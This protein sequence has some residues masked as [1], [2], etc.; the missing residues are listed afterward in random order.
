MAR[1]P[2]VEVTAIGYTAPIFTTIGA[3]LF[4]RERLYAHRV[5]GVVAGFLGT[6]IIL[7]PG[8]E[9]VEIGALAQLAAAP[10]F[11]ASFLIAKKLTETEDP[12]VIV[13]MLSVFCALALL[14]GAMAQWRPPT[15]VE[16]AWLFTTAVFAT[17]GHYTL[18]KAFQAAPITVIQPVSYLQLMWALLLG[19]LVFGEPV[20]P[21][22]FV[23]AAVIVAA[24]TYISFREIHR[25]G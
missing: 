1:I 19:V 21:W 14:P 11:A 10:F 22:V 16:L 3:A 2:I 8:F 9:T 24:V 6:L 20:D 12:A 25:P 5:I 18:T 13:A 17:L 23:G 15:G 4:L 7:R